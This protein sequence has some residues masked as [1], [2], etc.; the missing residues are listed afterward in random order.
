[1]FTLQIKTVSQT[2]KKK[3]APIAYFVLIISVLGFSAQ[4]GGSATSCQ[5][6]FIPYQPVSAQQS[7]L[8][9]YRQAVQSKDTNSFLHIAPLGQTGK[10]VFAT[11]LMERLIQT[12]RLLKG[13][14]RGKKLV[15][16]TLRHTQMVAGLVRFLEEKAKE[17]SETL[18]IDVF[19]WSQMEKNMDIALADFVGSVV[20]MTHR[21]LMQILQDPDSDN[22]NLLSS[23]LSATFMHWTTPFEHDIIQKVL[24]ELKTNTSAFIYALSTT[25]VHHDPMFKTPFKK[26]HWS[27]L[28]TQENPFQDPL[29]KEPHLINQ[30]GFGKGATFTSSYK[31]DL[32]HE[33][34]NK[35]SIANLLNQLT[36]GVQQGELTPFKAIEIMDLSHKAQE[37]KE[38]FIYEHA[39]KEL[40]PFYWPDLAEALSP[41][42][43]VH[44]KGFLLTGTIA[45][46]KKLSTF[47]TNTFPQVDFAYYHYRQTEEERMDVLSDSKEQNRHYIIAVQNFEIAENLPHLS[48]YIDLNVNTPIQDKVQTAGAVLNP[49]P[50][51]HSAKIILLTGRT[52]IQPIKPT[53]AK[54]QP[55][56]KDQK[57]KPKSVT[58]KTRPNQPK[59]RKK[60]STHNAPSSKVVA[61]TKKT[62]KLPWDQALKKARAA[63]LATE[64]EYHAWQEDHPDMPRYPST[65]QPYAEYWKGWNHFLGNEKLPWDQA[66]K[67]ARAAGL[68]TEKEYHAWQ[69]DHP[70]MPRFPNKYRPYAE[71]WK[72]WKH[73]L[74]YVLG[75]DKLPWDQALKKARAAGLTTEKEYNAWQEDHPD[76]PRF[77]NKYRPYAEYWEGWNHFLGYVPGQ[78]KLPW[79]QALKKAR[80]AG[81]SSGLDYRA[82]QKDHPD[83]PYNPDTY[84]PY[85]E[86]WKGWRHFLGNEKLPWDQALKKARAAGL[87]T[88]K[89]YHAWQEDH[90]DMPRSPGTYQPYAEYWKGWNHFLGTGKYAHSRKGKK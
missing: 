14:T 51:K 69:E 21:Q 40:N 85:A 62:N 58:V 22:V 82:W 16:A 56:A 23:H 59:K 8:L 25:P 63:G 38:L 46:A 75:Q 71:Y 68:A 13:K 64:K 83:M 27:Y 49:H 60:T 57:I 90:P 28:N 48:A 52:I 53:E 70:D 66:L 81:L 26:V 65:Y 73:F 33:N 37:G 80:A 79:D 29:V 4:V 3:P 19:Q 72:G 45:M 34:S 74:G 9:A 44:P 32:K 77:P 41:V 76:M 2:Q 11:A 10:E 55:P 35:I 86:Y 7:A 84:R 20:V 15:I 50:K 5:G 43:D 54:Y 1:M 31:E 18:D 17:Y 36:T 87:A 39:Q 12:T 61:K 89:E 6:T 24:S 78:D 42:F 67:K 30:T 88:E 47:L